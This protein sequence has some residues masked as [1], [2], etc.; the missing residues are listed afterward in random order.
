MEGGKYFN[1]LT[2][3]AAWF[4]I[5]RIR[6]YGEKGVSKSVNHNFRV[7]RGSFTSFQLHTLSVSE[8]TQVFTWRAC[9]ISSYNTAIVGLGG[10][11]VWKMFLH[12]HKHGK[13]RLS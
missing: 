1:T 9:F 5:L 4:N 8:M 3:F 10:E 2:P 7:I 11:M 13:V 6:G 12:A